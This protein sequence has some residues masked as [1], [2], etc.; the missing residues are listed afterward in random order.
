M[1]DGKFELLLIRQPESLAQLQSAINALLRREDPQQLIV[2]AK[3]SHFRF[4]SQDEA[5]WTLDGEFGGI[6][7][8]VEITN[9]RQAVRVIVPRSTEQPSQ[10]KPL[11]PSI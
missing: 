7:T 11:T 8:E 6:P 5:P 2:S 4:L 1:E 9:L 10:T 3:A